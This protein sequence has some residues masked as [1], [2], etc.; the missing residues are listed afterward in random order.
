MVI[1]EE[2]RFNII[3]NYI[4]NWHIATLPLWICSF[5]AHTLWKV[6]V[7]EKKKKIP[8][9]FQVAYNTI[10]VIKDA[11]FCLYIQPGIISTN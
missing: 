10:L 2:R 7:D 11:V 3:E 9:G 4:Y 6:T 1:W 5:R 8:Q